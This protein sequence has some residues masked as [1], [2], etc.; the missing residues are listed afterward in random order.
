M[1]TRYTYSGCSHT[2]QR[3]A[4]I[5]FLLF[6]PPVSILMIISGAIGTFAGIQKQEAMFFLIFGMIGIVGSLALP[7]TVH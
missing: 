6:A 5:T 2:L 7:L 3:L 4:G 1:K